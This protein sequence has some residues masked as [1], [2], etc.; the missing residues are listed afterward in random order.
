MYQLVNF[1]VPAVVFVSI[2]DKYNE[3]NI[4]FFDKRFFVQIA[5]LYIIGVILC[6]IGS[7]IVQ[8][9]M[10]MLRIINMKEYNKYLKYS[11]DTIKKMQRTAN[12]YRTYTAMFFLLMLITQ[13]DKTLLYTFLTLLFGVSYK[14]QLDFIQ[15]RLVYNYNKEAIK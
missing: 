6:R 14:K 12:E 9:I 5:L 8:P 4:N 11:D 3:F 1:F 2:L 15:Q 7:L 10:E 13:N